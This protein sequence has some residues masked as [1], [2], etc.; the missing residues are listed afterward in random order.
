MFKRSSNKGGRE[1]IELGNDGV[2]LGR[3]SKGRMMTR[4]FYEELG[5]EA[6]LRQI[7]E[8]FINRVFED[9]MIGFFFRNAD[10]KRI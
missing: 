2:Y 7:I 1:L 5:G 10:K 4:T 9:R 8:T 3:I 6:K